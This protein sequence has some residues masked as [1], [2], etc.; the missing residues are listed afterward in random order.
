M[1]RD[2]SARPSAGPTASAT[3]DEEAL[4]RV[5]DVLTYIRDHADENLSLRTMARRA[6][7][8]PHHFHRLFKRLTG[9]SLHRHVRSLR[10]QQAATLLRTTAVAVVQVALAA[11]FGSHESFSRAFRSAHGVSPSTYRAQATQANPGSGTVAAD[12]VA[13]TA[14]FQL[15]LV[16]IPVHDFDRARAF[17]RDALGIPEVAAVEAYGWASYRLGNVPLGLYVVG[18]GGGDEEPGGELAFH[19]SVPDAPALFRR[20]QARGVS[21]T[22]PLTTSDDGGAFFMPQDPDGNTFKI[23]QGR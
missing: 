8:S 7:C 23:C 2:T 21:F 1:T 11:G 4:G 17:Y 12:G 22:C 18:K 3:M 20:L 14:E 6:S 10:L 19:L 15:C 16:K 13:E 5:R 9:T